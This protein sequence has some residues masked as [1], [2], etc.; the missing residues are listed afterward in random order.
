[1]WNMELLLLQKSLWRTIRISIN[2]RI[3]PGCW[4]M[5]LDD[6]AYYFASII[7]CSWSWASNILL[8]FQ[9]HQRLEFAVFTTSALIFQSTFIIVFRWCWI[10]RIN[11][12]KSFLLLYWKYPL[13]VLRHIT[14]HLIASCNLLGQLD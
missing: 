7:T 12:V 13:F 14:Y 11:P 6:Y 3:I 8:L 5:S 1:M 4:S 10:C 2:K 9:N